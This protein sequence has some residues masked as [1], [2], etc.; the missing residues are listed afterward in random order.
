[1]NSHQLI[2]AQFDRAVGIV[3]GLPK[4]GPV[5]TDYEEKL[6]MYRCGSPHS[7]SLPFIDPPLF[8][9]AYTSKVL[10]RIPPPKRAHKLDIVMDFQQLW[11][12]SLPPDRVSG[13]C[14]GEQNGVYSPLPLHTIVFLD[15]MISRVTRVSVCSYADVCYLLGGSPSSRDAW[16][17][18][19]DL[20]KYEAKW[21]Y[22]DA[23]MK[24]SRSIQHASARLIGL[25]TRS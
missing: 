20:D 23:L 7:Y 2:D 17:K 24:V 3:Q 13:T 9:L 18:H 14:L 8:V 25:R 5:Q 21:L 10:T 11:V 6:T 12:M 4:N 19:K 15:Q 1:M 22:V 16:A